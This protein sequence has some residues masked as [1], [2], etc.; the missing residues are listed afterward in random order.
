MLTEAILNQFLVIN[1]KNP[2]E[3]NKKNTS[4]K[5][6]LNKQKLKLKLSQ[7]ENKY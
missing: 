1:M 5:S 6:S 3:N 2:P 7:A 4:C